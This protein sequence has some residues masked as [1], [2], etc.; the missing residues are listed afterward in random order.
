MTPSLAM[1][2][3]RQA[4][5]LFQELDSLAADQVSAGEFSRVNAEWRDSL[6]VAEHRVWRDLLVALA[7]APSVD[8]I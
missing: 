5:V 2:S 4:R 6:V 3:G 1:F 7:A 8:Q